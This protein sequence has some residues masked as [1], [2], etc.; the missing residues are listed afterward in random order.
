MTRIR[1][2]LDCDISHR[3]TTVFQALHGH[4]GFEFSHVT[5]F[6]PAA[7]TD[8][9]WADAFKRFGGHVVLSGD[10]QIAY[11]PHKVLSFIDNGFISFFPASPWHHLRSNLQAAFL[12]YHWPVLEAK[13]REGNRGS[14]WR[15]PCSAKLID[16]K[17][18][19]L[20][21]IPVSLEPL[22]IPKNVLQKAR[23]ERGI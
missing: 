23:S 16:G 6:A 4:R 22:V 7:S 20:R 21:L 11:K 17:L 14:C 12:V 15:I 19:D 13:I 18:V 2:T 10:G 8:D 3:M 5:E 1:V 9:H